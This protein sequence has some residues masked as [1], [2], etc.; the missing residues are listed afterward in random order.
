V[1]AGGNPGNTGQT[2]ASV[3]SFNNGV[4]AEVSQSGGS[5]E[6]RTAGL[7]TVNGTQLQ[8]TLACPTPGVTTLGFTANATQ[9]MLIFSSTSEVATYT[10]F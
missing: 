9:I 7:F 3:I 1:G 5:S 8:I 4:F 10:K 2:L 6:E